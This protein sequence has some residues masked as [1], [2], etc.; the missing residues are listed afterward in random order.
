VKLKLKSLLL[1]LTIFL[2]GCGAIT[3]VTDPL[4][5][6]DPLVIPAEYKI[7]HTEWF[8]FGKVHDDIKKEKAR[9]AKC[10]AFIK[11][12]KRDNLKSARIDTLN[13]V[14]DSTHKK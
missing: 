11:L 4:P 5:K 8:C 12:G 7:A 6:L 9:R 2:S 3:V 14:I 1:A 13:G 10:P